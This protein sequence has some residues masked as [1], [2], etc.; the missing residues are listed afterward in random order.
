[1]VF[2]K[3]YSL[4]TGENGFFLDQFQPNLPLNNAFLVIALRF[5][6]PFLR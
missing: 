1:M 6:Q 4:K 5:S 2:K 3:K